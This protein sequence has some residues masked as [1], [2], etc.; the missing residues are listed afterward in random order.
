[1]LRALLTSLFVVLVIGAFPA[2]AHEGHEHGG[3]VVVVEIEGALDQ[4]MIDFIADAVVVDDVSLVVLWIDSPG[5]AS[6]DLSSLIDLVR[7]AAIPIATWIGPPGAEVY[8]GAL[9][10]AAS[11][12]YLGAAPG[13]RIGYS[14]PAVAGDDASA[15][16]V[17][18][19]GLMALSGSRL[20][21]SEEGPLPDFVDATSPSIGQFLA[22]LDGIEI[23]GVVLDT[24]EEIR[25]ADG[26]VAT[27][28]TGE[29]R[30]LKPDLITRVLRLSI[31]PEAAF[32]FLVLGFALVAFEFYAAGIGVTAGVA[33]LSLLLSAYGVGALPF[34]WWAVVAS[35]VGVFLYNWDFQRSQL[36]WRSLL[37][38]AGLILGG[39]MFT[40]ADPQFGPHWW[41]VL[42]IVLGIALFYLFAMTTVVRSRFSTQTIGREYLIGRS[43][44]AESLFDPEG[45][46]SVDGAS[47]RG[48]AHRAAGIKSGDEVTVLAV[49]GI[50]LEVEPIE[51]TTTASH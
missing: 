46:V 44:I 9:Q 33:V 27:V 21:I 5:V 25:L 23:D 3:G 32:F 39:L 20:N 29:V 12:D 34:R 19:P 10:L 41:T 28:F 48:T 11:S 13:S 4:R 31:R 6:G 22:S 40:D 8:G 49:K 30:F 38:T 51:N 2:L 36:G 42:I 45:F 35:V 16:L 18:I 47:W 15:L 1:M 24:A 7:S 50:V 14:V 43:G 17:D 37:G 26:T